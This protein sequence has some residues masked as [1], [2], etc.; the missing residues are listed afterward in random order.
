MTSSRSLRVLFAVQGEGR[1]HLTQAL[2]LAPMLRRRGHEVVGVVAGPSRWGDVPDFFRRGIG[3]PVETVES[4][5]F[6]SDAT[7]RIL[8]GATIWANLKKVPRFGPSLDRISAA[9]E[10]TEPDVVVNFYD[11]ATYF[12][13][14]IPWNIRIINP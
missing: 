8:P 6:E 9:I 7:G 11:I 3:A 4:P 12:S 2:A 1:G 5:A 14:P 13:C 10:R